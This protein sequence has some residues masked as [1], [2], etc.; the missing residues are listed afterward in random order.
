MPPI[1]LF[2]EQPRQNVNLYG[3]LNQLHSQ[4]QPQPDFRS[5]FTNYFMQAPQNIANQTMQGFA[6]VNGLNSSNMQNIR[7]AQAQIA[8][9]QAAAQAQIESER[10]RQQGSTGRLDKLSPLLQS[11]LSGGGGLSGMGTNY[12]AGA[13]QVEGSPAKP[14]TTQRF[15][16][17]FVT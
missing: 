16:G 17:G 7:N 9:A 12:G 10:I 3:N 8:V 13:N 14:V 1:N 15:R 11:L 2:D 6:Y 5:A 4:M